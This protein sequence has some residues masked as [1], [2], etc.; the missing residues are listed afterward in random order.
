[1]G[2]T[3]VLILGASG[4]LGHMLLDVMSQ[5][6][7]LIVRGTIRRYD[8]LTESFFK[9]HNYNLFLNISADNIDSIKFIVKDFKPDIIINAIGIIKQIKEASNAINSISVNSL[10]PHI[11]CDM[12][13]EFCRIIH[14][15]TD[16][17]FDGEVGDY[18]E[19]DNPTPTDLY[20]RSK[21]LGELTT[22]KNCVTLRTSIIGHELKTKF[23]LLEWFINQEGKSVKG[24]SGAIF[25]GFPVLELEKIIHDHVIPNDLKGLFHV[26]A[27]PINKFDL[28]NI[29]K[30]EYGLDIQIDKDTSFVINRSLNSDKFMNITGYKR[31]SWKDMIKDMKNYYEIS[32]DLYK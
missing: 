15:S 13:S 25:S 16:C 1:M 32:K 10:F 5:R 23:G 24:F 14:I 20:G 18:N 3:K 2:K 8:S 6:E 31:S 28:L 29:I 7:D 19:D 27:Y 9:K 11:L 17:V 26:S 4:M 21:L 30:S 22:Y 12:F